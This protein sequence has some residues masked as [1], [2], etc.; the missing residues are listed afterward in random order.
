MPANSK[1][2]GP[3]HYIKEWRRFRAMTQQD[4]AAAMGLSKPSICRVESGQ[5]GYTQH[6]LESAADALGVHPC[7]LLMRS[8]TDPIAEIWPLIRAASP[9][10]Q[11]QM[12]L[13]V[14]E[15]LAPRP[16]KVL[17]NT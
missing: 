5:H 1:R 6:F 8:P 2:Q 11:Q 4:L 13:A 3:P 10:R 7:D 16:A 14:R 9:R 15:I 17:R 12:L